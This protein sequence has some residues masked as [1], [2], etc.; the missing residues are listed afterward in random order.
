[1]C[2]GT[3]QVLHAGRTKGPRATEPRAAAL[4]QQWRTAKT[5]YSTPFGSNDDWCVATAPCPLS[6]S[7]C[8]DHG[9]VIVPVQR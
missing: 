6:N 8:N 1:M 9:V 5:L 7:S 2:T 3:A 4:L